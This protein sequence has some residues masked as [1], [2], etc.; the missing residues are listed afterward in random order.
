MPEGPEILFC[1]TFFRQ[2]L[3]KCTITDIISYTDKKIIVPA[4]YVGKVNDVNCKG[5]Q[6]WIVVSSKTK[7][8]NYFLHIHYGL[9]G[10]ISN[11]QIND[12]NIKYEFIINNQPNLFLEDPINLSKVLILNESEH[13]K[14]IDNL[15]ID[16]FSPEFTLNVFKEQIKKRKSLLAGFL[17]NQNIFSG[18]GN[19]VKNEVL[20]M[21]DLKVNVK[22]NEL[23]DKDIDNLYKNILYVV[24]SKFMTQLNKSNMTKTDVNKNKLI[25]MPKRIN[26]NY[27]FKVYKKKV[28]GDGQKVIKVKVSGRDSYSVKE[29]LS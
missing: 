21:G 12:K 8:E 10:W 19:Y 27:S 11:E 2:Y 14:V 13:L 4:N 6:M 3:K 5:K 16:V 7:G 15:G 24:Y 23:T 29:L 9:D 25:N 17:L 20:F 1:T 26:K 18:M 28:T 22:T